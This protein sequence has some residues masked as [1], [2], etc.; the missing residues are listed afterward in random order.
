M[1]TIQMKHFGVIG[2]LSGMLLLSGCTR[3]EQA[4]ATGAVA[5]VATAAILG[6][7]DHPRYYDRPYYYYGGR[8]Y[9]GGYY[10]DGYYHYKGRKYRGGHYYRN[11][12]HHH[13][14]KRHHRRDRRDRYYN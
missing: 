4:F 3:T 1:G 9:Y 8:Y 11:Y 12:Y 7:Y 13:P 2:I 6:A 5:G 14:K 10:R